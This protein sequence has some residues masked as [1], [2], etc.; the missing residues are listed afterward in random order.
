M[1]RKLSIVLMTVVSLLLLYTVGRFVQERID[2]LA[3]ATQ[4]AGSYTLKH[5][6]SEETMPVPIGDG[7]PA[8]LIF[9][10]SWCP[11]CNQDA[12]KIV[13]LHEVYEDRV[14]ILG[15]NPAYRD[16]EDEVRKY[17][18]KHRIDYPILTDEVGGLYDNVYEKPGFP[19]VF[20]YDKDGRLVSKIVGATTYERLD[21]AFRKG[22]EGAR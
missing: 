14:H 7:K 6:G 10:A 19:S 11:Y 16:D 17:I 8:A 5:F 20:V 12:A 22:L 2:A 9:F 18:D 21:A 4:A 3:G 15:I 1:K 13:K